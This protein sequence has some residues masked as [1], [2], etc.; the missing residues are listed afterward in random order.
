MPAAFA[1][2]TASRFSLLTTP[3]VLLGLVIFGSAIFVYRSF[4][5][6][7]CPLGAWY[8]LFSKISVY[9]I[10]V[11]EKKSIGCDKCTRTCLLDC[12]KVG[13]REC[14]ACGK[15]IDKCPCKAISYGFRYGK[16]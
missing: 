13:D 7:L 14:I 8:S 12:E 11:D 9:A 2:L 5:R 16:D 6:F 15:C 1:G 3:R 4:C 10:K